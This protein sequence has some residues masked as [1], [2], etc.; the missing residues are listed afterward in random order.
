MRLRKKVVY[1]LL[2]RSFACLLLCNIKE[3]VDVHKHIQ[4]P[5]G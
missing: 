3:L 5:E 2:Q 1:V 4:F